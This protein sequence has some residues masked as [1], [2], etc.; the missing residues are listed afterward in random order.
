MPEPKLRDLIARAQS[1][2]EDALLQVINR[3]RPLIKKYGHG[4]PDDEAALIL[5]MAEAIKRYRPHTTWGVDE[6]RRA[7]RDRPRRNKR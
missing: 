4:I 3:F 6:L 1:G 7:G 5:R 2:D